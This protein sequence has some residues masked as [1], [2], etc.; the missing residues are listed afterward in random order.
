MKAL[1]L[2]LLL[3]LAAML[4][5]KWFYHYL[6]REDKRNRAVITGLYERA[7][8]EGFAEGMDRGL[9]T[10]IMLCNQQHFFSITNPKTGKPQ[11]FAC[12]EMKAL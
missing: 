8:G 10:I 3:S 2:A 7:H 6:D 1:L 9:R 12:S 5:L 4:G 11:R